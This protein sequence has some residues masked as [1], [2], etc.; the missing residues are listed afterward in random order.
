MADD[1]FEDTTMTFGDHIEGF[2]SSV[3]SSGVVVNTD[4][5]VFFGNYVVKIIVEPVE[6]QLRAWSEKHLESRAHD[7]NEQWNALPENERKKAR[8][9]A[10]LGKEDLRKLTVAVGGDVSKVEQIEPVQLEKKKKA[11]KCRWAH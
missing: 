1:L 2:T 11:R 3:P 8:L 5:L 7:F 4:A 9:V 6:D 10:T